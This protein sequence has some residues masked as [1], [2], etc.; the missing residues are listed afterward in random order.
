MNVLTSGRLGG[1]EVG[2][3]RR[4]RRRPLL[5]GLLL[6][7][8]A[9]GRRFSRAPWGSATGRTGPGTAAAAGWDGTTGLVLRF[10]SETN[11][12]DH[13]YGDPGRSI[14]HD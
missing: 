8:A 11:R 7:G 12:G 5:P 14:E 3:R 10:P 6:S 9:S 1:V 2:N 13:R 4:L